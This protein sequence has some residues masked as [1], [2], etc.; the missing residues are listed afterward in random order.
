MSF[1]K[2]GKF[3]IQI[4]EER[5][6][7][8][9]VIVWTTIITLI[10]IKA[11]MTLYREDPLFIGSTRMFCVYRPPSLQVPDMLILIAMSVVVAFILSDIKP[12]IYGFIVSLSASFIIAVAYASLFIWYVLDWQVCLPE[13]ASGWEWAIYFGFLNMIYVM[14]PWI[15]GISAIGLMVGILVRGWIGSS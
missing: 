5:K 3:N 15:I 12:I 10:M 11:H 1:L 6:D 9:A 14:V 7:I 8:L 2:I 13:L 4:T